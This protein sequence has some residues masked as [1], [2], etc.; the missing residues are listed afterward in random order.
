MADS[1]HSSA[2]AG[3]TGRLYLVGVHRGLLLF[4]AFEGILE[5]SA[6]ICRNAMK[7]GMD[8][9]AAA[10]IG[11]IIA[12]YISVCRGDGVLVDLNFYVA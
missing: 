12:L 4:V 9:Q 3:A 5:P 1:K 7:L 10:Y 8:Q 2:H 11:R 6:Y